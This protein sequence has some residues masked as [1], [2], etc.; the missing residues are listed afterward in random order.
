LTKSNRSVTFCAVTFGS[1]HPAYQFKSHADTA[2]AD[3][4]TTSKTEAA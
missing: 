2:F 3:A 4:S 1:N